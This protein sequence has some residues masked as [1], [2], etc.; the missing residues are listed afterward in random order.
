M[1]VSSRLEVAKAAYRAKIEW[2]DRCSRDDY[3]N[4]AHLAMIDALAAADFADR[5]QG[6]YR[7][8]IDGDV[9]D[10]VARVL[11]NDECQEII[12]SVLHCSHY[13]DKARWI[14]AALIESE[15]NP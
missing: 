1:I 5:R 15:P 9:V 7:V 12:H 10:R 3:P 4:E 2:V 8:A 13:K 6:V 14:I 11:H